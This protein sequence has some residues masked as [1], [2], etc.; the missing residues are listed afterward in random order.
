[1][2]FE[3][4]WI[5]EDLKVRGISPPESYG[6][7]VLYV[8]L[9]EIREHRKESDY[10][11]KTLAS[12]NKEILKLQTELNDLQKKIVKFQTEIPKI[13]YLGAIFGLAGTGFGILTSNLLY[14]CFGFGVGITAIVGIL[15][16]KINARQGII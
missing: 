12:A 8:I 11:F 7:E 13:Y 16:A 15:E 6:D 5:D 4:S 2:S 9:K 14:L 1:M 3:K 10:G